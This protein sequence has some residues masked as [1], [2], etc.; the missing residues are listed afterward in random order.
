MLNIDS[1]LQIQIKVVEASA[2]ACWELVS[3][4]MQS[5]H[6]PILLIHDLM[7]EPKLAAYTHK[8][9]CDVT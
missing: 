5:R 7:H 3:V 8:H 4:V 1:P 6:R 2:E 9:L